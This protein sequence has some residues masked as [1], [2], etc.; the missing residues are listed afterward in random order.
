MVRDGCA[1]KKQKTRKA[2]KELKGRLN[3]VR[4]THKNKIKASANQGGK[5]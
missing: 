1:D 2:K 3:K 5:K 4:G